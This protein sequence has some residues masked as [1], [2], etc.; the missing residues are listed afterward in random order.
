MISRFHIDRRGNALPH[1]TGYWVMY[2]HHHECVQA[3]KEEN[4]KLREML[5]FAQAGSMLYHDDGEL[6]D[7]STVPFIDYKRDSV[8]DIIR[9]RTQRF[10][11]FC[12]QNKE[13]IEQALQ[14]N[15]LQKT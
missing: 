3:L 4:K 13:A 1:D 6:Q 10:N 11:N 14:R 5:A 12:E 2:D 8:D 9:K 7:N 15:L